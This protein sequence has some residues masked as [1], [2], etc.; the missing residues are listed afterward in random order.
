MATAGAG[1][2][3]AAPPAAAFP[4]AALPAAHP[5]ISEIRA[6]CPLTPVSARVPAFKNA[7]ILE[8]EK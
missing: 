8:V 4:L 5:Q 6:Q 3:R 2:R 1:S 7:P